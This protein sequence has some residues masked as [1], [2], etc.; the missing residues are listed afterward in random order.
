MKRIWIFIQFDHVKVTEF[1]SFQNELAMLFA[2]T[3]IWIKA[4]RHIFS[5][6]SKAR[7]EDY[8]LI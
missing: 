3:T 7:R 6:Q 5:W 1:L 4:D 2:L 8:S